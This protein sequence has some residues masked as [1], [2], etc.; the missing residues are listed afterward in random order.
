MLTCKSE[1]NKFENNN[2]SL[3]LFHAFQIQ[4]QL[5]VCAQ[6]DQLLFYPN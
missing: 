1:N 6:S 3:V 4:A 2:I 5:E